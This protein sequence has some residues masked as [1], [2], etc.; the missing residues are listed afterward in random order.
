MWQVEQLNLFGGVDRHYVLP[1]F[2]KG[3]R[4][5]DGHECG[6]ILQR[7]RRCWVVR[8]DS[9]RIYQYSRRKAKEFKF[10]RIEESP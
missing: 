10:Q 3:D 6:T 2:Q 1:E 9:G 7:H 5:T 4:F 8:W